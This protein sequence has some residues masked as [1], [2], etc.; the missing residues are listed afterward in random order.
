VVAAATGLQPADADRRVAQVMTEARASAAQARRSAVILGFSTAAALAA[1]AA[2][3][4]VAA[5]MGGR[6]RDSEFAP[7][8]RLWSVV[9]RPV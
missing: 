9:V 2:A 5:G 7:P 4:W 3:A 8:L 1:A 6:H